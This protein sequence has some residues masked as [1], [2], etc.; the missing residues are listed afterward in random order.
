MVKTKPILI[1]NTEAKPVYDSAEQV[2]R[3]MPVKKMVETRTTTWGVAMFEKVI[4]VGEFIFTAIDSKRSYALNTMF[5]RKA[6]EVKLQ[7]I[8][9]QFCTELTK[10]DLTKPVSLALVEDVIEQFCPLWLVFNTDV[11]SC[12]RFV[13]TPFFITIPTTYYLVEAYALYD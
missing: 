7:E 4:G 11:Y 9:I 8:S 1:F 10:I 12:L 5:F 6:I 2:A 3:V 13:N